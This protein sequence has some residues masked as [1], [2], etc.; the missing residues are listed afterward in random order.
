MIG[1]SHAHSDR[2]ELHTAFQETSDALNQQK[3]NGPSLCSYKYNDN[4]LPRQIVWENEDKFLFY[5][6]A[7][8]LEEIRR[9]TEQYRKEKS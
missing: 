6:E 2:K 4:L 3:L 8:N 1:I 5:M 7:G 9:L